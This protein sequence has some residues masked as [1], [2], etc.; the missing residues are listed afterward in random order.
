WL[1]RSLGHL[2]QARKPRWRGSAIEPD[3]PSET[4]ICDDAAALVLDHI[5][6]AHAFQ[7]LFG[8]FI[9]E[10]RGPLVI[11]LG[12][13][14]VLRAAAPGLAKLAHLLERGGMVWRRCL[15]EQR[16]GASVVFFAAG[17]LGEHHAELVLRFGVGLGGSRQQLT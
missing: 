5:G 15:L 1:G 6:A 17:A 3:N 13:V 10:R 7:R 16:A 14:L 12:G 8:G 2:R 4:E 9:A 11:A